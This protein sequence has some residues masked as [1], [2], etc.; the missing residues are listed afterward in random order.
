MA[1]YELPQLEEFLLAQEERGLNATALLFGGGRRS[2]WPSSRQAKFW[3]TVDPQ[4]AIRGLVTLRNLTTLIPVLPGEGPWPSFPLPIPKGKHFS[5]LGPKEWTNMLSQDFPVKPYMTLEYDLMIGPSYLRSPSPL[6]EE[7][8]IHLASDQDR[9]LLFPLQS[10]Y[11]KEEVVFSPEEFEPWA[12]YHNLKV[13]LEKE[14]IWYIQD[15]KYKPRAKG[16]TNASGKNWCQLGGIF[17]EPGLRTLGLGKILVQTMVNELL[18]MGY[19][20]S[21]F[22]KKQ[23][24]PALK[25]YKSLGFDFKEDFHIS[26]FQ[27]P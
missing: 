10:A 13:L 24:S 26:Y 22:V 4:G 25:L 21:L 9:D 3:K 11:E 16:G 7:W 12:C 17:T 19:R 2:L 1:A 27:Q 5:L 14:K 23:N 15:E 20:S 18:Q 8:E 6:P